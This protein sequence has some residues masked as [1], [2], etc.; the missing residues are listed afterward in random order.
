MRCG[1][2]GAA[3][4]LN[5]INIQE[6]LYSGGTVAG[7]ARPVLSNLSQA[8]TVSKPSLAPDESTVSAAFP[9]VMLAL[10]TWRR[11]SEMD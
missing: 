5:P 2:G 7:A 4:A 9:T 1:L 3:E 6:L 10:R 11:A 8:R